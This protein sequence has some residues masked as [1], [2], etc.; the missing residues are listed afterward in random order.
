M[1]CT[2]T[3]PPSHCPP[4]LA[5][6]VDRVVFDMDG[7][8]LDTEPAYR[9][10]FFAAL[11]AV[12]QTVEDAFYRSI[13]GI[14]SRERG[15][16]LQRRFGPDFPLERFFQEYYARKRSCFP[17]GPPLKPGALELLLYLERRGIPCAIVTSA[18]SRTALRHLNGC[19]LADHFSVIISRDE[20][21]RGKPHPEGF[22]LAARML[23]AAPRRCLA[24]EDSAPGIEAAQAAGMMPVMVPDLLPPGPA[25]RAKC[26]AV[27]ADLHDVRRMLG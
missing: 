4:P 1:S 16:L 17:H 10:A 24:L 6:A 23:D 5:L 26:L 12:G 7:T 13:I 21:R 2:A 18:T 8:L 15:V 25:F 27:A 20:V 9:D 22:L 19:G 11:S 14:S 3:P